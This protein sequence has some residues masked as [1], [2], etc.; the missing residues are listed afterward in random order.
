M[1]TL[2]DNILKKERLPKICLLI[3]GYDYLGDLKNILNP[4][5]EKENLSFMCTK[6]ATRVFCDIADIEYKRDFEII[7]LDHNPDDPEY[8]NM[9]KLTA[10]KRMIENW[11]LKEDEIDIETVF[12]SLVPSD[13]DSVWDTSLSLGKNLYLLHQKEASKKRNRRQMAYFG[14]DC[15]VKLSSG[16]IL[17]FLELCD[18]AFRKEQEKKGIF[19]KIPIISSKS[20]TEAAV[21][22][23]REIFDYKIESS[24]NVA[25][26]FEE[27]GSFIY[28]ASRECEEK[29][30]REPSSYEGVRIEVYAAD[31][32][33]HILRL[34]ILDRFLICSREEITKINLSLTYLPKILEINR[35]IT[36]YFGISWQ[37]KGKLTFPPERVES[38]MKKPRPGDPD[39]DFKR[40][41]THQEKIVKGRYVFI[42]T[43]Y[44]PESEKRIKKVRNTLKY[45]RS[46]AIKLRGDR[47]EELEDR[48]ISQDVWML[49]KRHVGTYTR[50]IPTAISNSLY[51]VHDITVPKTYKNISTGVAYEM[52]LSIGFKIP[53]L[54]FW[55]EFLGPFRKNVLPKIVRQVNVYR[56]NRAEKKRKSFRRWFTEIDNLYSNIKHEKVKCPFSDYVKEENDCKY[57]NKKI[58]STNS[59]FI[60]F[61]SRNKS[62][63]DLL[64][65]KLHS[66]GKQEITR[67]DL[68]EEGDEAC[69]TCWAIQKAD[70][71]LIDGSSGAPL[72]ALQLGMAHS[73]KKPTLMFYNLKQGNDPINM[74][75]GLKQQWRDSTTDRGIEIGL[76]ELSIF[77]EYK[78][79]EEL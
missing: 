77:K 3:D 14:F 29:S 48:E 21:E 8:R 35:S 69:F 46:D 16:N 42:S 60:S 79:E 43:P 41:K 28:W 25:L 38:F 53:Y 65:E 6:I 22:Y 20:Q 74:Y 36:P 26:Y 68:S 30:L 75:M 15:F 56:W 51:V 31:L 24:P 70:A 66:W 2:N 5:L 18:L 1:E 34:G 9:V 13:I 78:T 50:Y 63:E 11:K 23:A 72:Y 33:K 19:T 37:C 58:R 76:K 62:F 61:Q 12:S 10:N 32:P 57:K 17:T 64:I 27:L 39:E 40:R 73:L 7:C 4:F 54:L 49:S 47:L 45:L 44:S 52:G 59:I 67:G 55:D 71:C